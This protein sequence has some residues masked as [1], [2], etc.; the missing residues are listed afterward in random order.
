[1]EELIK[2]LELIEI[3]IKRPNTGGPYY[4][5]ANT[6]PTKPTLWN[7]HSGAIIPRNQT[8]D[9]ST[10]TTGN[11]PRMPPQTTS[12]II[13]QNGGSQISNARQWDVPV[14]DQANI[15]RSVPTWAEITQRSSLPLVGNAAN[16]RGSN[17]QGPRSWRQ[18]LHLLNGAGGEAPHSGSF[19]A[20]I[21]IVAYNVAKNIS[22]MDLRH[23]LSQNGLNI[24][25]CKLLTTAEGARA[26]SYKITIDPKDYERA[27]T[28]ASLWPYRVGVRLFKHFNNTTRNIYSTQQ[29]SNNDRK[30]GFQETSSTAG[31]RDG[32]RYNRQHM[33]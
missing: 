13:N 7:P 6:P 4:V 29:E 17:D 14:A 30:S 8:N 15:R 9:G 27:T 16:D 23:W 1:M 18:K 26:L 24:K 32:H 12:T 10:S 21:D 11:M 28:D 25:D 31:S 5:E 22:A 20:D 19:S 3:N 33:Y 2:R